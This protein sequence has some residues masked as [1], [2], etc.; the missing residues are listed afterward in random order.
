MSLDVLRC[1]VKDLGA[2][3][4]QVAHDGFTPVYVAAQQGH[5]AA[6]RCLVNELGAEANQAMHDI[7]G[8]TPMHI[9]A[10]NG[11][12]DVVRCLVNELHADINRT[13]QD[14]AT[15]LMMASFN[16]HKDIVTW[17]IKAGADPHASMSEVGTAADL[18]KLAGASTEQT[19][20]LD[21]KT[22]CSHPGC[23]GAGIK[24]CT[25]CKQVRYCGEPCQLV[26]WKAHKTDCRRWSAE[27]QSGKVASGK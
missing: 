19:E 18:S 3:A 21:A 8:A 20:Y 17:L 23:S 11:L 15:P 5:L 12:L 7:F 25:G 16:K 9:A 22:H 2:D 6:M 1:L 27:L 13:S 10:Q 4:N 26:H 14:G 24:K